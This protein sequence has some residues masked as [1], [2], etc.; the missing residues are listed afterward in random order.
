[1]TPPPPDQSDPSDPSDPTDPPGRLPARRRRSQEVPQVDA[2]SSAAAGRWCT[3]GWGSGQAD[4]RGDAIV[5]SRRTRR[6]A[7]RMPA[8][9]GRPRRWTPRA[10][11]RA[12]G[13]ARRDG[14]TGQAHARGDAIVDSRRARRWAGRMPALPARPRR[15]T[16]RAVRRAGGG[17]RRDGG[18]GK[19][20]LAVMRLRTPGEHAAGP[21]GCR[22]S[23]RGPV[24]GR[25]EQGGGRA[26]VRGG[27][28]V[29]A[30]SRSR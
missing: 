3:A 21:A 27:M 17:A 24:G 22:R 14:R 6:W 18:R 13:G 15:W 16:P 11:R 19:L 30:S 28:G 7:G 25:R 5:D 1:M 26:M 23:Q 10:V 9:P 8:L 12:G 29:K 4:A 20:T 2:A